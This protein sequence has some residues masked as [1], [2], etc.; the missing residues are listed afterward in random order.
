MIDR[1]DLTIHLPATGRGNLV[2]ECGLVL[3]YSTIGPRRAI[4]RE[5]VRYC[6]EC[7]LEADDGDG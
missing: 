3:G 1:F 7:W 2:T 5:G 6:P 4:E